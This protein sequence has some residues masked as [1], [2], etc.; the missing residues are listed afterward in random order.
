MGVRLSRRFGSFDGVLSAFPLDSSIYMAPV[1]RP[2]HSYV[3]RHGGRVIK[4]EGEWGLVTSEIEAVAC[5]AGNEEQNSQEKQKRIL[6]PCGHPEQRNP[7]GGLLPLENN[8]PW[9]A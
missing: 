3:Q 5:F 4:D 9:R 1:G 7:L 2:E 8:P 6:Q